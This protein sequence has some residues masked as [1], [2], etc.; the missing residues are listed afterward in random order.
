MRTQRTRKNAGAERASSSLRRNIEKIERDKADLKNTTFYV[1][2][3]TQHNF[4]QQQLSRSLCCAHTSSQ[5]PETTLVVVLVLVAI[6]MLSND[7]KN[8]YNI[9]IIS[10]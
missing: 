1:T 10:N 3:K 4:E 6:I 7:A 9:I 2:D 5:S 8:A